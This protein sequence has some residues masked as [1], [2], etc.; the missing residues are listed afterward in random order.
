MQK[1]C[2][3]FK[4]PCMFS[5]VIRSLNLR[6]QNLK[7][8]KTKTEKITDVP[9]WTSLTSKDAKEISFSTI[10]KMVRTS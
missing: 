5:R 8:L 3:I 10:G 1:W 9:A 2:K 6:I 4:N 7:L